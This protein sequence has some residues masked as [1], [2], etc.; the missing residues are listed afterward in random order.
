VM[1]EAVEFG[2]E[3]PFPAPEKAVEYVYA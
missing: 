2:L 1:Q 3:S